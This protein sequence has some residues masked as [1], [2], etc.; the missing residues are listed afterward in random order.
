MKIFALQY[1]YWS[2]RFTNYKTALLLFVKLAFYPLFVV[3]HLWGINFFSVTLLKHILILVFSVSRQMEI[4]NGK[5][6][7][8]NEQRTL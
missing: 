4:P 3:K 6:A 8:V 2:V 7:Y 1:F 5:N